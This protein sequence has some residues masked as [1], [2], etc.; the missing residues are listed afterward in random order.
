MLLFEPFLEILI[1]IPKPSKNDER[2]RWFGSGMYGK[3]C[4][5]WFQITILYQT[6]WSWFKDCGVPVK[7][8]DY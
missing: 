2:I 5:K 1:E 7:P 3:I 4:L 8:R 6:W